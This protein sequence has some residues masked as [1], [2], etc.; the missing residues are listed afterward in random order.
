VAVNQARKKVDVR[1]RKGDEVPYLM[2]AG[3]LAKGLNGAG[4]RHVPE[5][6]DDL[7]LPRGLHVAYLTVLSYYY[8][9][10]MGDDRSCL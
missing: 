4:W 3:H 8:D 6:L 7:E 5:A 9:C 2:T 1:V 10:M